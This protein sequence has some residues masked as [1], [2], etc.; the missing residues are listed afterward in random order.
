MKKQTK[1]IMSIFLILLIT[2]TILSSQSLNLVYQ[3]D[4]VSN[5]VIEGEN[6]Y[7][8]DGNKVFKNGDLWQTL[9]NTTI[10]DTVYNDSIFCLTN[11]H[12]NLKVGD[13]Y[14]ISK[15]LSPGNSRSYTGFQSD[16]NYFI[17][18]SNY[19][20]YGNKIYSHTT[21]IINEWGSWSQGM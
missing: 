19:L 20:S 21:G 15:D 12:F 4:S 17:L 5:L 16:Q 6:W 18:E 1:K 14:D 3:G 9:P 11:Q 8:C 7:V 10:E 13:G 2:T